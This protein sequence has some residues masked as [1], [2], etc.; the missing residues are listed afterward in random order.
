ML[1]AVLF[2]ILGF[3]GKTQLKLENYNL[4]DESDISS[5]L[6]LTDYSDL[7]DAS[8]EYE[9]NDQMK[10]R[11]KKKKSRR[12]K[13]GSSGGGLSVGVKAGANYANVAGDDFE[14][15]PIIGIAIGGFGQF[16]IS[17]MIAV[18]A[19]LNFEQK[20]YK[21]E[22]DFFGSTI[23]AQA[24]LNYLTIPIMGRVMFGDELK[25]YAN[26]GPYIG[27]FMGGT[28]KSTVDGESD[29]E[30]ID[31]GITK[32]D[33]GIIGGAGLM[34]P[35]SDAMSIFVD[36]RYAMGLNTIDDSGTEM[37]SKNTAIGFNVGAIIPL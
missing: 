7:D 6:F 34:F 29:S 23:E 22:Y 19:E 31:E 5:F 15:K 8:F 37:D 14:Q 35:L 33:I 16:Q 18:V 36:L 11:R 3:Q 13:K 9:G 24:T 1:L 28:S 26:A 2:L 27:L 25:I 4:L 17:D 12:G 21:I 10:K 30:K 20:G 32:M